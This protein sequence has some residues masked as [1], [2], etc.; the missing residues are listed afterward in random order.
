MDLM[1]RTAAHTVRANNDA[2]LRARILAHHGADVRFAFLR[3]RWSHAWALAQAEANRAVFEERE[4]TQSAGALGGLTGYG[5]G[6][7][8]D[9]DD[10]GGGGGGDDDVV[11]GSVDNVTEHTQVLEGAAE[12]GQTQEAQS[13]EVALRATQE[14]RRAKAR[15]WADKR[16]AAKALADGEK[17]ER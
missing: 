2:Q 16:R 12:D 15:E 11:D 8:G 6:S 14:A 5:S 13:E 9:A 10:D 7:E 3:G 1:R 4:K 17:G